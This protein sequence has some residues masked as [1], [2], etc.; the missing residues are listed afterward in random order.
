ML[1]W[2]QENSPWKILPEKLPLENCP[3]II[4]P[5][6]IPTYDNCHG[7]LPP[8]NYPRITPPLDNFTRREFIIFFSNTWNR[9]HAWRKY[10]DISLFV[11]INSFPCSCVLDAPRNRIAVQSF[12]YFCQYILA[13]A[14]FL[15]LLIFKIVG[16][17]CGR[18]CEKIYG[19]VQ[20]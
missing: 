3:Q 18:F 12:S 11:F 19:R 7:Q 17:S 1:R 4:T 15:P 2:W 9:N 5:W 14:L 16:Y 6:T 10:S 13:K 8:D 20:F